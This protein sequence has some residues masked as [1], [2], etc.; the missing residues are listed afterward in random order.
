MKFKMKKIPVYAGML[1]LLLSAGLGGC[2]DEDEASGRG[3][4]P[5]DP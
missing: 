4:I 2:K 1:L 3:M 5:P